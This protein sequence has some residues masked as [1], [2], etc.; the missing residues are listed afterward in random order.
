MENIATVRPQMA[1]LDKNKLMLSPFGALSHALAEEILARTGQAEGVYPFV[2]LELLN[3]PEAEPETNAKEPSVN[4]EVKLTLELTQQARELRERTE[5]VERI[6]ERIERIRERG[7]AA[8]MPQSRER[9]AAQPA[10]SRSFFQNINQHISFPMTLSVPDTA[11]TAQPGGIARISEK[12]ANTLRTMR[13][14]GIYREPGGETQRVADV[15]RGDA[16]TAGG[17]TAGSGAASGEAGRAAA[18]RTGTSGA[19][20]FSGADLAVRAAETELNTSGIN[21]R[22]PE[23]AA[24]AAERI[25]ERIADS[26]A[27]EIAEKFDELAKREAQAGGGAV[28]ERDGKAGTAAR[29]VD[30]ERGQGVRDNARGQ[31]AHGDM[32]TER[33]SMTRRIEAQNREYPEITEG[34]DGEKATTALT[35]TRDR[36]GEGTDGSVGASPESRRETAGIESGDRPARAVPVLKEDRPAAPEELTLAAGVRSESGDEAVMAG[37]EARE[38]TRR[39]HAKEDR[40]KREHENGAASWRAGRN[41]AR[42]EADEDT[43]DT[44]GMT[45]TVEMADDRTVTGETEKPGISQN[46]GEEAAASRS[47]HDR[48]GAGTEAPEAAAVS[49]EELT[50]EPSYR[51]GSV[52]APESGER[53][54]DGSYRTGAEA[55]PLRGEHAGVAPE[56]LALAQA[57]E[58]AKPDGGRTGGTVR[59]AAA[60]DK[61]DTHPH[62]GETVHI[63]GKTGRQE[64]SS[65]TIG[66]DRGEET[67]GTGRTSEK[68]GTTGKTGELR[69]AARNAPKVGTAEAGETGQ[70]ERAAE[71]IPD[72]GKPYIP[73]PEE[74]SLRN[75]ETAAPE[76]VVHNVGGARN[77][78]EGRKVSR[79]RDAVESYDVRAVRDSEKTHNTVKD[80]EDREARGAGEIYDSV[81]VR[82]T[83]AAE[84]IP[85]R[86]EFVDVTLEEL[87]L[88]QAE[89]TAKPDG[90]RTDGTVR[91]AAADEKRDTLSHSGE[92]V[93]I[94]GKTG[95]QEMSSATIGEDRGEATDG[96]GR[97]SEKTGS[98]GKVDEL[99]TAERNALKV[100][101][102]QA[103]ETG[104]AERPVEAIP[105]HGRPYMPAPEELA[106]RNEETAAPEVE[107][108]GRTERAAEAIPDYGKPYMP[109]PEELSLR[110]EETVT[111]EG[112]TYN[113]GEVQDEAE[114]REVSRAR[115]ARESYD[116]REVRDTEK[117]Y[118]A[119]KNRET[120]EARGAGESY[121]AGTIR[122]TGAAE[123]IP[124]RG[125][126]VHVTPEELAL[127]QAENTAKPD[128]VRTDGTVR[129]AAADE[130]RDTHHHGG[131]TVH[132]DGKTGRQEMSS[133]AIREDGG[134]E[135]GGTGRTSEK[136]GSTGKTGELRTAERNAQKVETAEVGETGRTERA[137]EAIPERERPYMPAP[138]E[139]SLR[140]EETAAPEGEE[141]GRTERAAEAIPERERPY[142]P[143]PEELALRNEETGAPDGGETGL[144]ERPVEAIPDHGKPYMPAPEELSLRNEETAAPEGEETGRTE[145]AAEAIP[146]RERL[147]MPAPEE[148]A[149]RNEE[150]AASEGVTYNVGDAQNEVEGREVS[151]ARDVVES[152]DDREAR[153]TEKSH[154]AVKDRETREVRGAGESYDAGTVYD[155]GAAE[156]IPL[157]GE[158]V[159]VAPEE[160]AL[161][162]AENTAKPDGGRTGGTVH[163]AAADEKRDN[164]PHSG[165]KVNIDGKTGRPGKTS[166]AIEEDRGEETDGT[167]RT[168]EKTGSTGKTGGHRTAERNAPKVGTAEGGE[169]GLAERPVE[170]IPDHGKPHMPAPEELSLRNEETAAS[171]GVAILSPGSTA[172]SVE[173][174]AKGIAEKARRAERAGSRAG[175]G[176]R[177]VASAGRSGPEAGTPRRRSAAG[178]GTASF[179]PPV[180]L[181]GAAEG[182]RDAEIAGAEAERGTRTE[183]T[184]GIREHGDTAPRPGNVSADG[185]DNVTGRETRRARRT[186]ERASEGS[187]AAGPAPVELAYGGTGDARA[188]EQSR[189]QPAGS[190]AESEY[191]KS[192]PDWARRFLKEGAG[193]LGTAG[194]MAVTS[195][196]DTGKT[197]NKKPRMMEWT[198]PGYQPTPPAETQFKE[199]R[200]PEETGEQAGEVHIS[201]AE[202]RRTADRVYK[203]IEDRIRRERRR[204]GL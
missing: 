16:R 71:A 144:A 79:A 130:K 156:A 110:N 17:E 201:D 111:P 13:E 101:T 1:V 48:E 129:G 6:L 136:T 121:D 66:E 107:E 185:T 191:V 12:F 60:D 160:L 90:G 189:T 5:T 131:E 3:E 162:Q 145:K 34:A 163:G 42:G 142:M 195:I 141:T 9:G 113:V 194:S 37:R 188:D 68:I 153:N 204:L 93:H 135:T 123:A 127:A 26:A 11:G 193:S 148:L 178:A 49:R 198:A 169:T 19:T 140:N 75:E 50:E 35:G 29:N 10:E 100:E 8:Q 4:V 158:Y 78:V 52:A 104:L 54:A 134:E 63:D 147:Y 97:T 64:M 43:A 46:A 200:P 143:A 2:P 81:A 159:G 171:E 72:H 88:A 115:D 74:L 86:G 39:A 7:E 92:T 82:D 28:T 122:D 105:D 184:S 30:N 33:P 173:A 83:G 154:N 94:D 96:T 58:T 114:G 65:A 175:D 172:K 61:H 166:A 138:E 190:V 53:G 199:L 203:M 120:R 177:G 22:S 59:G 151:K 155:T 118:N 70:S 124:L 150:T 51:A 109:T 128:G 133:A 116:V 67:D 161:A 179:P 80:R 157:R 180:E 112:V 170:A 197:Q 186:A 62:D 32:E 47:G 126:F 41:L 137:A 15:G 139:L 117:T 164:H 77:E 38:D 44:A 182:A 45:G 57:E 31:G 73:A 176:N 87:A 132:I 23:T 192:L 167:G 95:R 183:R 181:I 56:E 125:E 174:F 102:V 27:R 187:A 20:D 98:T 85:L 55:I 119:V 69:T 106:L 146:E 25:G 196:P 21:D 18:D 40:A 91:G 89:E 84:A 168:S 14:E 108:T 165:E 149:L 152:Y 24:R 99:R 36:T 202:I 103:G 76:G